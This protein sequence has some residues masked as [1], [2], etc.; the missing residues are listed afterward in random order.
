[1]A[2]FSYDI[3]EN[4]GVISEGTRGWKKELNLISWSGNEPKYDIRDWSPDHE[5]MTK[6]VT[7]T[8]EDLVSLRDLLNSLDI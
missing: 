6:G 4:L 5:K 7:L 8:K 2:D 1:M 3:V